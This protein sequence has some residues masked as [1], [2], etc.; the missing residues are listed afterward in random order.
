MATSEIYIKRAGTGSS[1]P[2]VPDILAAHPLGPFWD[3]AN[4]VKTAKFWDSD[5][6][7]ADA[8]DVGLPCFKK[9]DGLYYIFDPDKERW[10]E[11]GSWWDENIPDDP[12]GFTRLLSA[13]DNCF[14]G[15]WGNFDFVICLPYIAGNVVLHKRDNKYA[16]RCT[17]TS[18]HLHVY[19]QW[20]HFNWAMPLTV[21]LSFDQK[22][23]ENIVGSNRM[24]LFL[25]RPT[26]IGT[27]WDVF[28]PDATDSAIQMAHVEESVP[29]D[30]TNNLHPWPVPTEDSPYTGTVPGYCEGV[31]GV[32][33]PVKTEVV[34]YVGTPV[35]A[36]RFCFDFHHTPFADDEQYRYTFNLRLQGDYYAEPY[37]V[38]E[39]FNPKNARSVALPRCTMPEGD[40]L[41][42]TPQK[43]DSA[44][45]LGKY[46]DASGEISIIKVN[47]QPQIVGNPAKF[48]G[49]AGD[50]GLCRGVKVALLAVPY[51]RYNYSS[52]MMDRFNATGVLPM[53]A[54]P[55]DD[56]AYSAL[57]EEYFTSQRLFWLCRAF[58]ETA[59]TPEGT[60]PIVVI[61]ISSGTG[62]TLVSTRNTVNVTVKISG[63]GY[64]VEPVG[65]APAPSLIELSQTELRFQVYFADLLDQ[66]GGYY[67]S[68]Q[69][70]TLRYRIV[71]TS[72]ASH[73]TL[74]PKTLSDGTGGLEP[75][76]NFETYDGYTPTT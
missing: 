17:G 29:G 46:R 23:L 51:G 10:R 1:Q 18:P 6:T 71:M 49:G 54:S 61:R 68:A 41:G 4:P 45:M 22:S 56:P 59:W 3:I 27:R 75:D 74:F 44:F 47:K 36:V 57:Y 11:L 65:D 5:K 50:E 31:T 32:L 8:G 70:I 9:I 66:S 21:A 14:P 24:T 60:G 43:G 48:G 33:L 19:R 16:L 53:A 58:R 20:V 2:L 40:T 62:T 35:P 72:S 76:D 26:D 34:D 28:S 63:E 13:I 30:M 39:N 67:L 64:T 42:L 37:A 38:F 25:D 55:A 15:P 69:Q 7:P 12:A 73:Y 52:P